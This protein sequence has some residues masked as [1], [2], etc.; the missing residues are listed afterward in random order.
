VQLHW[1]GLRRLVALALDGEQVDE[2]WS[3]AVVAHESQHGLDV[4][5]VVAIN[6]AHVVE[7]QLLPED[8]RQDG[9]LDAALHAL[10]HFPG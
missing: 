2:R 10:A 8:R 9:A 3:L 7:A 6:R 4:G 1:V 5:L